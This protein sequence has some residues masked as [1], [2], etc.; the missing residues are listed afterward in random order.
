MKK[1]TPLITRSAIP[2]SA[3]S[4]LI[5]VHR[6][7]PSGICIF[8]NKSEY[9]LSII[10]GFQTLKTYPVVFGPNPVDDKRMEG[11]G[12]TPEGVFTIRSLY[13]H[14]KWS[15]FL[16]IDYPTADSYKK[17]DSAKQSGSIPD[18]AAIGGEIGIHGVPDSNDR[19]IND[20]VN[21]TAG[22]IALK[23]ADIDE[24]FSVQRFGWVTRGN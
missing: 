22:C 1:I 10:S 12:S 11:D 3:L 17:F 16:W 18:D 6:I 7:D 4:D 9:T 21:W 19:L 8:I 23:T 20:K 14:K 15:K 13:P 5:V 2:D 24:I